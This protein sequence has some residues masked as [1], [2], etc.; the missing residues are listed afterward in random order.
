MMHEWETTYLDV[1]D[2]SLTMFGFLEDT[3]VC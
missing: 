3:R 1:A 2:D